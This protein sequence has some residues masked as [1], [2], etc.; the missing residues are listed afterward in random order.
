MEAT[1]REILDQTHYGF[2]IYALVLRHYY[3]E[4]TVLSLSGKHCQPARNPFRENKCTLL[5]VQNGYTF[6]HT[7]SEDP[8]FKGNAFD[9]ATL[10]YKVEGEL[11]YQKLQNELHIRLKDSLKANKPETLIV[12]LPK[13][14]LHIPSFSFYKRPVS[15]TVPFKEM[16]LVQ[17]YDYIKSNYAVQ[18]TTTLRDQKELKQIRE[19]K[20]YNFDYVTFS[21][22]FSKRSDNALMRHSGLICVDFDHLTDKDSLKLKLLQDE[23]FDTEMLFVSPS[24]DGLKWVLS[25]DIAKHSHSKYFGGIEGY[26]KQTY[27]LQIDPSGK[28]VSRACFL[29]HDPEVF[30]NTKYLQQ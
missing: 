17:V 3:P 5:I 23:Y 11:L 6:E 22:L 28:D 24:G 14:K 16:D 1:E 21:G 27:G 29:P 10:H 25:I 20:K 8:N 30:I 18:H 4:Q 9:F 19:Y 7:D 2:K 12:E 15:N 26:I 13:P